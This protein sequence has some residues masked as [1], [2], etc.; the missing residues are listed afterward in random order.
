VGIVTGATGDIGSAIVRDLHREGAKLVLS[1]RR[2]TYAALAGAVYI[3]GDVRDDEYAAR[4][5]ATAEGEFGRLDLLV[6]AHGVDYHADLADAKS[7]EAS[8]VL[9]VNLLGAVLT[10][11]HA[12][13]GLERSG[14]GAI[15][16][17]ASRLGVVAIPGQAV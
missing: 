8:G 10:M 6:N 11:E 7:D 15:V 5:A 9:N 13:P 1:G 16:N 2:Q 17:V 4:L 3:P 14:T 12:L